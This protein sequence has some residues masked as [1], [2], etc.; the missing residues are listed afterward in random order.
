ME[1]SPGALEDTS[2]VA[3]F[4]PSSCRHALSTVPS[5]GSTATGKGPALWERMVQWGWQT[6]N[7]KQKREGGR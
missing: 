2:D 1:E 4:P 5:S 6:M 7:N 3:L